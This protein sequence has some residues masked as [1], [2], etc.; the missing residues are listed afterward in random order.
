MEKEN[1]TGLAQGGGNT[2][3]NCFGTL[4]GFR[5]IDKIRGRTSSN[6]PTGL[7]VLENPEFFKAI[8]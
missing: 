6:V 1:P 2:R 4:I 7:V 3:R 5:V 8:N